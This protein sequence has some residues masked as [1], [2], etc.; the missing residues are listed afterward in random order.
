M[1]TYCNYCH[2][3]LPTRQTVV[4]HTLRDGTRTNLN[5][6]CGVGCMI[7]YYSPEDK[8]EPS[9][10]LYARAVADI[11][12]FFRMASNCFRRSQ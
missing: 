11:R 7:L 1:E 12:S 4:I 2:K 9:K 6:F 10:S 8:P 3:P 5:K